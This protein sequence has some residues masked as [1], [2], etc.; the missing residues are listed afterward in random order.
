[1]A[2][3]YEAEQPTWRYKPKYKSFKDF[4]RRDSKALEKLYQDWKYKGQ[5]TT[6]MQWRNPDSNQD[7]QLDIK[8]MRGSGNYYNSVDL[9]RIGFPYPDPD[10]RT[11]A[12]P[13]DQIF[14]SVA[15]EDDPDCFDTEKLEDFFGN[16]SINHAS[17]QGQMQLFM[18]HAMCEST[19]MGEIYREPFVRTFRKCGCATYK[20]MKNQITLIENNM[21]KF[22]DSKAKKVNKAFAKWAFTFSAEE[23][24]AKSVLF[25]PEEKKE[26][27]VQAADEDS[28]EEDDDTTMMQI[29]YRSWILDHPKG[30]K[31]FPLGSQMF[32]FLMQRKQNAVSKDSLVNIAEF[33]MTK[34]STDISEDELFNWPLIIGDFCQW[35]NEQ[36]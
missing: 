31:T 34:T 12:G 4:K 30:P 24:K 2:F 8:N 21:Y 6:T 20:E 29:M 27:Q 26:E 25:Y 7:I 13:L 16:L 23:A 3:Y 11:A 1:M 9:E 32:Q 33:M 28:E 15:D 35:N 10:M 5:R 17:E 18:F 14:T 36:K 19:D 22:G